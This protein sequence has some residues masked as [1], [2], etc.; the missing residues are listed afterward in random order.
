[1]F[2]IVFLQFVFMAMLLSVVAEKK[3]KN[4]HK[5]YN[6][7]PWVKTLFPVSMNSGDVYKFLHWYI[8]CY[9][10]ISKDFFSTPNT[11]FCGWLNFNP[12]Y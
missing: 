12:Q 1:M 2:S 3:S 10:N 9:I 4:V 6:A 7:K 5:E 11:C 8:K